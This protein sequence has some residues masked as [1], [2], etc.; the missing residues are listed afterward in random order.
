MDPFCPKCH[1]NIGIGTFEAAGCPV[2]G[3][4]PEDRDDGD[5]EDDRAEEPTD[6][7]AE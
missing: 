6:D 7:E 3:A 2:C 5:D 4:D 1:A